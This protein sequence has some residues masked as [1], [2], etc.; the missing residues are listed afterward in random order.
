VVTS[1]LIAVVGLASAASAIDVRL[2]W[3]P[4]AGAAG[5]RVYT[6]EASQPYDQWTDVGPGTAE[7]G[8]VRTV[9]RV[10]LE[11]ATYFAMTSY[12]AE[13]VETPFSNELVMR[14]PLVCAAT[15]ITGCRAPTAAAAAVLSMRH[16]SG[17][18]RDRL[19]WKWKKGSGISRGDLGDPTGATSYLLCI[20]DESRGVAGLAA[21]FAFPAGSTCGDGRPCWRAL[22]SRGFVYADRLSGGR[23]FLKLRLKQGTTGRSAIT[24]NG[25]G[26]SLAL[27]GYPTA[28]LRQDPQ[29]TVQLLNDAVPSVCWEAA[30]SA[31]AKVSAP[32]RFKDT[33]D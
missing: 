9:I 28:L 31:A 10:D 13:G 30:Y 7:A 11:V 27:L 1:T 12:D 21:Q 17:G 33:S 25:K 2:A 6:R 26:E 23:G 8:I 20:Y 22:G 5:Y 16:P 4:A 32:T 29:V 19:G 18:K 3:L 15:P 14:P 24:V